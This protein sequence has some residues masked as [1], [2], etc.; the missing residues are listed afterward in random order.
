MDTSCSNCHRMVETAA[1]TDF[2]RS[3]FGEVF[4]AVFS[5]DLTKIVDNGFEAVS[6]ELKGKNVAFHRIEAGHFLLTFGD[7]AK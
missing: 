7:K 3:G 2:A 5:S 1:G 4:V 6:T